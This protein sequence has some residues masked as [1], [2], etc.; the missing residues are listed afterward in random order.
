LKVQEAAQAAKLNEA[1]GQVPQEVWV[2]NLTAAKENVSALPTVSDSIRRAR[3]AAETMY[4][5]PG[6]DA[7]TFL[8]QVMGGF[9]PKR[10]TA[11]QQFKTAMADVMAMHRKAI[12][13][14]GAQSEAELKLLQQSSAA[15]AKLTPDTIREALD[16]ADRLMLKTA[17]AH[18]KQVQQFA[19]A[20]PNPQRSALTFGAYG[21]P[22]MVE[23]VKQNS[24]NKLF[25]YVN[26]PEMLAQAQKE[27]D[28]SYHTP[29]LAQQVL[30]QRRPQ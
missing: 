21:I 8:S 2:K 1:L 3:T 27:L 11:T 29:G 13:G 17:I 9:D 25:K 23:M 24:V 16:T 30:R 14:V 26:D 28:N 20:I 22:N 19:E 5:G 7:E 10:G 18:Q 15:D 6:A 12:V 4:T